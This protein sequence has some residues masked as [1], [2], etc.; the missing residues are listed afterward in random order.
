MNKTLSLLVHEK[1][2]RELQR[3]AKAEGLKQSRVFYAL[4][5][6]ALTTNPA[7]RSRETT[8]GKDL[9]ACGVS[10]P[11]ADEQSWKLRWGDRYRSWIRECVMPLIWT[12]VKITK[13]EPI[14]IGLDGPWIKL[15]VKPEWKLAADGQW[16][17]TAIWA[18]KVLDQAAPYFIANPRIS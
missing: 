2:W 14:V 10:I 11:V 17:A 1:D 12:D 9:F 8:L 5:Q 4:A 15:K 18:R 6:H 13:P 16:D 7:P 3:K